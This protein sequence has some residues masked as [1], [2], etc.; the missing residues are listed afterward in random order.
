ML[1]S[2]RF[3]SWTPNGRYDSGSE[4]ARFEIL[5]TF[6]VRVNIGGWCPRQNAAGTADDG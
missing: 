4:G 6:G 2:P 3:Y 1:K 5:R